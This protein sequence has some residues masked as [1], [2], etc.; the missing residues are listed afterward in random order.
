MNFQLPD[1][2]RDR[3][4]NLAVEQDRDP[5]I[6]TIKQQLIEHEHT[7]YKLHDNIVYKFIH[8]VW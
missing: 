7:R 5:T 2:L 8:N 1:D 4:V 6:N 3:L